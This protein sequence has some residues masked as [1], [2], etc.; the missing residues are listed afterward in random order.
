MPLMGAATPEPPAL[1]LNTLL[2]RPGLC[3]L[4]VSQELRRT[5]PP[6]QL[7]ASLLSKQLQPPHTLDSVRDPGAECS[8]K[9]PEAGLHADTGPGPMLVV[10]ASAID[11]HSSLFICLPDTPNYPGCSCQSICSS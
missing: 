11:L 5:P 3:L 8:Y 6:P 7:T 4:R 2:F 9:E 10:I 1:S